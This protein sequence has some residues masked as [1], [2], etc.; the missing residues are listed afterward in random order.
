MK[1][2]R[3]RLTLNELTSSVERQGLPDWIMKTKSSYL[4][5]TKVLHCLILCILVCLGR[6]SKIPGWVAETTEIA[7]SP[8][9]R[10]CQGWFWW[11]LL[12]WLVD[13]CLPT[14]SSHGFS[15]EYTQI[16]REEKIE[17]ETE[18]SVLFL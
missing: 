10:S 11:D 17:T 15:S 6:H 16:Q 4:I 9:L 12:S 7:R 3:N 18:F 2:V 8:R 13:V 1:T 14:M 5:F